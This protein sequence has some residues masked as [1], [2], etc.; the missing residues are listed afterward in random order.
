MY[1]VPKSMFELLCET[2]AQ[3]SPCNVNKFTQLLPSPLAS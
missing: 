2:K 1:N 3:S